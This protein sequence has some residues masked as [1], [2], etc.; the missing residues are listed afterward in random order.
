MQLRHWKTVLAPVEGISKVTSLCW[1]ANN[2]KFAAV[3]TD[4]VVYLF[5]ENG[6]RKDKFKTKPADANAPATYIVRGMCFSPDSTKLV[7][8]QSDNIVFV[9]RL[10][11]DWGEKKSICNKFPQNS[12]ITQVVWPVSRPT[13]IVFGLADGKVKVGQTKNNKPY[14]LY[15]HP[16]GSYVVSLTA[17]LDG[18][19]IISG[20]LDCSI[21]RFSFEGGGGGAGGH[22]KFAQHS[23]VPYALAWGEFICAAGSDCKVG[24]WLDWSLLDVVHLS[25]NLN[26]PTRTHPQSH[27]PPHTHWHI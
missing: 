24:G 17:S 15:A 11:L 1:S 13:E 22:S 9:Y 14:T 7:I 27:P 18:Y 3:T 2:Q 4:R 23:A 5:D 10:G 8:A 16:E 20:H 21:Y 26:T 6:D 19:S 25:P 12:P